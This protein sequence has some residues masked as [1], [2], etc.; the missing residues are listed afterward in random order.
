MSSRENVA[1]QLAMYSVA[2]TP[3]GKSER[4]S[5]VARNS[6]RS[7]LGLIYAPPGT[8]KTTFHRRHKA[9]IFD[10]DAGLAAY[11]AETNIETPAKLSLVD[12]QIHIG[13]SMLMFGYLLGREQASGRCRSGVVLTNSV[14]LIL[15]LDL[16]GSLFKRGA[17]VLPTRRSAS[18]W[19]DRLL[20]RSPDLKGLASESWVIESW[21]ILASELVDPDEPAVYAIPL[22]GGTQRFL[23]CSVDSGLNDPDYGEQVTL[24]FNTAYNFV[25]GSKNT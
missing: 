5:A 3:E 21:D 9:E 19:L 7:G 4:I 1:H 23:V 25:Q 11:Y 18:S 12:R 15:T 16:P 8:G 6:P 10:T 2:F 13:S 20:R 14:G 24:A 17:A 22:N